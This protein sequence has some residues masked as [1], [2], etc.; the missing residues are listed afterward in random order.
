MELSK[1]LN[2]HV[3]MQ[4]D[5]NQVDIKLIGVRDKR[6]ISGISKTLQEVVHALITIDQ[7]MTT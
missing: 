6:N 2:L 5:M 1:E 3:K 4:V 7:I